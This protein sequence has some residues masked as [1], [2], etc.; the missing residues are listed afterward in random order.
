MTQ[1]RA[2]RF[3]KSASVEPVD[4]GFSVALDG[5]LMRTPGKVPFVVPT[6]DLAREIAIEWDAQTDR[7]DPETMPFTRMANSAIDKVSHQPE[8][9]VAHLAEYAD[10]D[11]LCYRADSPAELVAR[12]SE[13]WDPY[14][15]WA[16]QTLGARLKPRTGITHVAQDLAAIERLRAHV[17]G[18]GVFQLTGFYD[19]VALSGSVI[20]GFAAARR[21]R[22]VTDVWKASRVDEIWQIELWGADEEA[23]RVE[24]IRAES[25][26]KARDF[27]ELSS[28][29]S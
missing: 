25:F 3:W 28:I 6:P 8:E 4:G 5:R 20:L 12:Q 29:K 16:D 1:H 23:E 17:S 10:S 18:L 14:L 9:V 22:S 15:E 13:V 11:L 7:I 24:K 2:K 21:L 27:F 26:I 19:L